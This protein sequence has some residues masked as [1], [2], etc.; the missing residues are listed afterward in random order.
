[1]YEVL[2]F[3]LGCVTT[4]FVLLHKIKGTEKNNNLLIDAV[5]RNTK[6]MDEHFKT[7]TDFTNKYSEL[8]IQLFNQAQMPEEPDPSITGGML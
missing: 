3:V 1:M 6:L 2:S 4:Y 5:T 7:M 8:S